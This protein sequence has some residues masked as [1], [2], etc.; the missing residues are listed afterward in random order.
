MDSTAMLPR[1]DVSAGFEE[2]L[3]DGER[4]TCWYLAGAAVDIVV[5][6]AQSYRLGDFGRA[7]ERCHLA[8]ERCFARYP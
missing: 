6:L 1:L 4:Q 8:A 5:V 2:L 3:V 7:S